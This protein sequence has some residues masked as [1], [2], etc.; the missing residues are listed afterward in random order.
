[1]SITPLAQVQVP[2]IEVWRAPVAGDGPPVGP[3]QW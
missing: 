1:V 3:V 2:P